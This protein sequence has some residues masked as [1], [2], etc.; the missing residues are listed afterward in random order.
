MAQLYNSPSPHAPSSSAFRFSTL[1]CLSTSSCR[2]LNPSFSVSKASS[3]PSSVDVDLSASWSPWKKL[4]SIPL[5]E[6]QPQRT[7]LSAVSSQYLGC[8]F[9]AWARICRQMSQEDTT[10][11]SGLLERVE[12]C[13]DFHYVFGDHSGK[14]VGCLPGVLACVYEVVRE[15]ASTT[16]AG[17]YTVYQSFLAFSCQR[18]SPGRVLV[19]T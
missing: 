7:R 14:Y 17:F 11:L 18:R 13:G 19:R 8:D 10:S 3:L 2:S 5:T 9:H 1:E 6:L 15:K 16:L 4:C 12:F